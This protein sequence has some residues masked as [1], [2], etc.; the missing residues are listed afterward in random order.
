M[1]TDAG[2]R[3][4]EEFVGPVNEVN[5]QFDK[6]RDERARVIEGSSFKYAEVSIT[7][8]RPVADRAGHG[9]PAPP[10]PQ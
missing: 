7:D 9:N 2:R 5:D 1:E 4:T 3:M 10:G 8:G 6:V